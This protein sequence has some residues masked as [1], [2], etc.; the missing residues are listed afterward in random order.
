MANDRWGEVVEAQR[1]Y[2]EF[3]RAVNYKDKDNIY[4]HLR[5]HDKDFTTVK[6]VNE[7]NGNELP[8]AE[9]NLQHDFYLPDNVQDKW[10]AFDKSTWDVLNMRT[11]KPQRL[12]C[13]MSG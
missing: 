12:L 4:I 11:D 7:D 1:Q 8:L 6:I 10:F 3:Q 13:V 5:T 2:I 9:L